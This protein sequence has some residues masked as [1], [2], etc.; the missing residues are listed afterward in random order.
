MEERW[1]A[2]SWLLR[3]T[4]LGAALPAGRD[5]AAT[6]TASDRLARAAANEPWTKARTQKAFSS[7]A[8][9]RQEFGPVV[10]ESAPAAAKRGYYLAIALRRLYIALRDEAA[11]KSEN[12]EK[13]IDS[14]F[15][16][17]RNETTFDGPSY[18]RLLEQI[19]VELARN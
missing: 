13:A 17:A 4:D 11:Y 14:L 6:Q 15:E 19:E 18:G 5:Y 12:I 1:Q 8:A 10:P 7:L 3:K 9:L 2:I 16:L